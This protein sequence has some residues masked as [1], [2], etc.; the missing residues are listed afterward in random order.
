MQF[1]VSAIAIFLTV[2]LHMYIKCIYY[3]NHVDWIC[4]LDAVTSCSLI[5]N[6]P[7]MLNKER[8]IYNHRKLSELPYCLG[9]LGNMKELQEVVCD[10]D[11]MMS[12]IAAMTC[13]DYVADFASLVPTVSQYVTNTWTYNMWDLHIIKYRIAQL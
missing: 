4:Y 12:K 11:W 9:K 7:L 13:E 8:L 1:P 3:C 10:W 6:Q 5:N 2:M